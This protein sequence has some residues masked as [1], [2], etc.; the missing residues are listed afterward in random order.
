M[1]LALTLALPLGATWATAAAAQ[2]GAAQPTALRPAAIQPSPAA[3]FQPPP[4]HA[5][6]P[7]AP[8]YGARA[9]WGYER[10]YER[11]LY[12]RPYEPR[13]YAQ[14][15]YEP[16][17]AMQAAPSRV[18]M[19]HELMSFPERYELWA[20]MR[21]VRS[22]AERHELLAKKYAELEKRA[23]EHG[24]V[25]RDP[26][27]P[28]MGAPAGDRTPESREGRGWERGWTPERP[29]M[30]QAW[31]TPGYGPSHGSGYGPGYGAP[32]HHLQ[33]VPGR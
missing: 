25:L 6:A 10:P 32:G 5:A 7:A 33:P 14:R 13:A 31:H 22:P 1:M 3:P 16:S 18:V 12:E 4:P 15:P 11:P 21:E 26:A 19:P 29:A 8:A 2:T 17:P 24:L 9:P 28:M 30:A 23:G 20:K 27:A